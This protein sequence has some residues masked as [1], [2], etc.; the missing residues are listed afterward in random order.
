MVMLRAAAG[1]GG[2][3]DSGR[4]KSPPERTAERAAGAEPTLPHD[5]KRKEGRGGRGKKRGN[6]GGGTSEK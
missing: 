5:G 4:E 2:A 1:S 6:R 3:D